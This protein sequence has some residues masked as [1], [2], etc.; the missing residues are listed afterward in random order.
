MLPPPIANHTPKTVPKPG[1][2]RPVAGPARVEW[3]AAA[4]I[5]PIQLKISNAF[6]V[7][8]DPPVLVDTGSPNEAARI[9][10]AL[11]QE[12]VRPG[13]LALVLHTHG[14]SDHCG[15]TWELKQGQ[16]RILAA[17]HPLDAEMMRQGR[18][19]TL[20]PTRL[21]GSLLLPFVNVP[22]PGVEPDLLID[23]GFALRE[24]GLKGKIVATPGHT[25]G[26]ISIV[27]DDGQA[28]VGDL[29]MGGYL[30]GKFLPRLPDY[31]YFADD[32]TL[33]QQSVKKLVDLGV[34]RFYV[35]HGGPLDYRDVIKRFSRDIRF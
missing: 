8:G 10:R 31:H 30:G 34:E 6:L 26:S 12:G 35:G 11:E 27:F 14:H 9:A 3:R 22:F 24:Y 33:V 19:G 13:D 29:I 28:I 1:E 23:E 25:A 16:G 20:K 21:M 2:V 4:M 5:V 18:N 15:S 17:I 32:L 7:K